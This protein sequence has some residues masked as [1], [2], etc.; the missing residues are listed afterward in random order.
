VTTRIAAAIAESDVFRSLDGPELDRLAAA[1]RVRPYGA[2]EV[3]FLR[4]DRGDCMYVVV[5][6]SV[7]L[8]LGAA[9]GRDVLLAVLRPP[10]TFGELA[11]VDGGPRVAT[12]LAR[13]NAVLVAVPSA[14]VHDL[15]SR[16]PSTAVALLTSLASLVRRLDEEACDAAVLD[17]PQRV[18]KLLLGAVRRPYRSA[19]SAGLEGTAPSAEVVGSTGALGVVG[20]SKVVGPQ[21]VAGFA[22]GVRPARAA[23]VV[24]L[25]SPEQPDVDQFV[26][27]DLALTQ[28]DLAR[29][30]GGSRQR[31]NQVL[32]D[33]EAAGAIQVVGHRVV[34][35]RPKQ[36]TV[37]SE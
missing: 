16:R 18:A 3:V 8:S 23:V 32:R 26:P 17:L 2:G 27:V 14:A 35:V 10:D 25:A 13:P 19:G 21:K 31:V 7:H 36:L 12:A 5:D 9:T 15:V 34:G 6:G 1:C 24:G 11:V 33:L 4:G 22:P 29:R 30:V 37:L 20:P 28:G